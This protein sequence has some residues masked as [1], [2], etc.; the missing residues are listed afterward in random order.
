VAARSFKSAGEKSTD[1]K[2][3][4]IPD[5]FPVGIKTPLRQSDPLSGLF[6][7]HFIHAHQIKDNF[8]NLLLTNWGERLGIYKFGCN[9]RPLAFELSAKDDFESEAM[10]RI[11]EQ[12]SK[13]MP[14]VELETFE[15]DMQNQFSSV[16][17]DGMTIVKLKVIYNV[18]KLR[19]IKD[20]INVSIYV[21]G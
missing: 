9:L 5:R 21:A 13:Y 1:R 20:A 10:L 15:S 3:S 14:Y 16:R 8:R 18:P 12:A 11:Q 2:F 7:M 17:P 6:D 4:A 19:V